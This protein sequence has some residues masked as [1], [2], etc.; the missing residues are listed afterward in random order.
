MRSNAERPKFNV[1]FFGCRPME[2]NRLEIALSSITKELYAFKRRAAATE[3]I[4]S[5]RSLS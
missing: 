4:R 5:G 2:N 1:A 3:K